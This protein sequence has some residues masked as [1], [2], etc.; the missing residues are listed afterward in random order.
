MRL[1]KLISAGLLINIPLFE[2]ASSL[3]RASARARALV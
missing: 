1:H 3:V 2:I